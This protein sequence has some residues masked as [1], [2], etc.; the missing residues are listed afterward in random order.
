M[1]KVIGD[2][3]M[4]LP[5]A[6]K[7]RAK[8]ILK[9]FDLDTL[10]ENLA[11]TL[12]VDVDDL[13]TVKYDISDEFNHLTLEEWRANL[14]KS[15]IWPSPDYA[16]MVE[17]GIPFPSVLGLKQLYDALPTKAPLPTP[18]RIAMLASIFSMGKKLEED[19]LAAWGP[20]LE[21]FA[22]TEPSFTRITQHWITASDL[23]NIK[24]M[25]R[26]DFLDN[27]PIKGVE[28]DEARSLVYNGLTASD[29]V[30]ADARPIAKRLDQFYHTHMGISLD[31]ATYRAVRKLNS[32]YLQFTRIANAAANGS[33]SERVVSDLKYSLE[34]LIDLP[35]DIAEGPLTKD[36]DERLG[37]YLPV[38]DTLKKKPRSL[39]ANPRRFPDATPENSTKAEAEDPAAA[40]DNKP[41]RP[42]RLS[43]SETQALLDAADSQELQENPAYQSFTPLVEAG[44]IRGAQIG[45]WVT[46][47]ERPAL[48]KKNYDAIMSLSHAMNMTPSLFGLGDP[49]K[50]SQGDDPSALIEDSYNGKQALGLAFGA[51]G[52]SKAAAH[53]E[54]SL[55]IINLT[56]KKGAGSLAHEFGHALDARLGALL[57]R[58][59][60]NNQYHPKDI[61]R[62]TGKPRIEYFSEFMAIFWQIETVNNRRGLPRPLPD[63][64][65]AAASHIENSLRKDLPEETRKAVLPLMAGL[66]NMLQEVYHKRL[67]IEDRYKA[68]LESMPYHIGL[69]SFQDG[70]S[71]RKL[72]EHDTVLRHYLP[73]DHA[74]LEEWRRTLDLANNDFTI[75]PVEH[76]K[77]LIYGPG[78]YYLGEALAKAAVNDLEERL[79]RDIPKS[80]K[81]DIEFALE[82]GHIFNS[83]NHL[84]LLTAAR[85]LES[86]ALPPNGHVEGGIS[87]YR[88]TLY[89]PTG[90]LQALK[91]TINDLP[92]DFVDTFITESHSFERAHQTLVDHLDNLKPSEMGVNAGLSP[93]KVDHTTA[94][95]WRSYCETVADGTGIDIE[96]WEAFNELRALCSE[97]STPSTKAVSRLHPHLGDDL[98][99]IHTHLTK[100]LGSLLD[101]GGFPLGHVEIA[102]TYRRYAELDGKKKYLKADDEMSE[103]D[104]WLRLLSE[105]DP[106]VFQMLGSSLNNHSTSAMILLSQAHYH[107]EYND[108]TVTS[109]A[110]SLQNPERLTSNAPGLLTFERDYVARRGSY[111]P[112]TKPSVESDS[113]MLAELR[114]GGLIALKRHFPLSLESNTRTRRPNLALQPPSEAAWV[115]ASLAIMQA[116]DKND[117]QGLEHFDTAAT[118][119]KLVSMRY[120]L[121][122]ESLHLFSEMLPH[123]H[124][125]TVITSLSKDALQQEYRSAE[126][127][128][129]VV[130]RHYHALE[131]DDPRFEEA[132]INQALSGLRKASID[133]AIR[134]TADSHSRQEMR[135]RQRA[136][137][138]VKRIRAAIAPHVS[139]S[140]LLHES[141]AF[142]GADINSYGQSSSL[143]LK[144]WG[145]PREVFARLYEATI[146]RTL[147]QDGLQDPFLVTVP[148]DERQSRALIKSTPFGTDRPAYGEHYELT[149]PAGDELARLVARFKEDVAP[150]VQHALATLSP[151]SVPHYEAYLETLAAASK[152]QRVQRNDIDHDSL[153]REIAIQPSPNTDSKPTANETDSVPSCENVD[154]P[155]HQE[156]M[157]L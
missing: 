100:E 131:M 22:Q 112:G 105:D 23:N 120:Q 48:V 101:G 150:N 86:V 118:N 154:E 21:A 157:K 148:S 93:I 67:S 54:P 79:N 18:D 45:N 9:N 129:S 58:R 61:K 78:G 70:S 141:V 24:N 147:K 92:N 69:S 144:Y 52:N 115:Y 19:F 7:D 122:E 47:K 130:D 35:S 80:T 62:V 2:T 77:T 156:S 37:S 114:K 133:A 57:D 136:K 132:F 33:L 113:D 15:K 12:G 124:R 149:Y 32:D 128:T 152:D 53:F 4:I 126:N 34:R 87:A 72:T 74:D 98:A 123:H 107:S 28:S 3:G 109:F 117:M 38:F 25:Y 111:P 11:D 30:L 127:E 6:P 125:E 94:G 17:S 29:K 59:K 143:K 5:G 145:I 50:L 83:F 68:L 106:A 140:R 108:G 90:W 43:A 8:S 121:P 155:V 39:P 51:R 71:L 146:D 41:R 14:S 55:F 96:R 36:Q 26:G 153:D 139:I 116:I 81:D 88:E 20:S 60:V 85:R 91:D 44:I 16:S 95:A 142:D 97:P 63:L 137:D 134:T 31:P 27:L 46:Q 110:K 76:W 49:V 82:R 10:H 1:K 13:D 75:E 89:N 66:S 40:K 73:D 138:S 42:I 135:L 151:E 65:R 56:R 84:I 102:N 64:Q 104:W 99:A 119:G 103:Q